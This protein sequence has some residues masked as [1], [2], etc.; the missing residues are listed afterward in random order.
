MFRYYFFF[1]LGCF[2]FYRKDLYYGIIDKYSSLFIIIFFLLLIG[3]NVAEKCNIAIPAKHLYFTAGLSSV[4]AIHSFIRMDFPKLKFLRNVGRY[5]LTIYLLNVIMIGMTK[6]I[7]LHF[8]SWNYSNFV[9]F[10][11]VLFCAGIFLPIIL[12]NRILS[13]IPII[14]N[15]TI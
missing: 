2:L 7:L 14:K 5:C 6:G 8:I 4:P 3:I 1:I 11:P 10:L 12:W 15:I 13:K 9:I